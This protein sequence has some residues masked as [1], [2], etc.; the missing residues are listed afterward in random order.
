MGAFP[1]PSNLMPLFDCICP[2]TDSVL[3]IHI[4]PLLKKEYFAREGMPYF[5]VIVLVTPGALVTVPVDLMVT[6]VDPVGGGVIVKLYVPIVC[7]VSK[8][9]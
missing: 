6:I 8:S 9:T 5:V 7:A 3:P 2:L 1:T 4:R